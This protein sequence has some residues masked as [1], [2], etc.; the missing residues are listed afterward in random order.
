M[1]WID[2]GATTHISVSMQGCLSCRK[3]TNDERYIFVGDGKSVEIEAI[4]TFRLS[5]KTGFYLDLK[6]TFIVLSFRWNLISISTLDKFG[7]SC[8]FGN[9]KFSLFHDSKMVGIGSLSGYDNLYLFD[10]IASFNKSLHLSTRDIK[11]KLTDANSTTLWHKRLGHISKQ[12]IERLVSDRILNS[13]DF[14]DFDVYVNCIKGKQT[15]I[16]RLGANRTSDI[17]ELIHT[18]ICEPFPT[19]SWKGQ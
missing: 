6:E 17:L 14:T 3:P 8:S 2:Y 5:S 18:D 16:R 13:L 12:R 19:A 10:T 1:W 9:N 15:N 4:D 11:R 7:Y